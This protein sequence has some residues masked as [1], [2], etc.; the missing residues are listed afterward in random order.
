MAMNLI[1]NTHKFWTYLGLTLIFSIVCFSSISCKQCEL[2]FFAEDDVDTS[3][4]VADLTKVKGKVDWTQP[5]PKK[6]NPANEGQGVGLGSSVRT[7]DNSSTTIAFLDGGRLQLNANSELKLAGKEE[8]FT[9]LMEQGE[10][11]IVAKST[12]GRA[13]GFRLI[14][15]D[16][17]EMVLVREGQ[18]KL[19]MGEA[20][21]QVQMMIGRA[22]IRQG[23]ETINIEA[24]N[25]FM[26]SI[27]KST[28]VER[29]AMVTT[30]KDRRKASRIKDVDGNK[31]KRINKKST[32]IE[33][34]TDIRVA[35][36]RVDLVDDTGSEVWLTNKAHARFEG[37]HKSAKGREG[38]LSLSKGQ[39]KVR[40]RRKKGVSARQEI[41]TPIA[42]VVATTNGLTAETDVSTNKKST[43]VA[44][45]SGKATVTAG[46]KTYHLD[47][48]QSITIKKGGKTDG[49]KSSARPLILAREGVRTRVFFDRKFSRIGFACPPKENSQKTLLELSRKNTFEELI[50]SEP[51]EGKYFIYSA[52]KPGKYFWRLKR[53]MPQEEIGSVGSLEI[54]KDPLAS[55]GS[56]KKL[57][58]VV[59]DTGIQTTVLFQGRAPALTFKWDKHEGA[60]SYRVRVYSED[61]MNTPLVNMTSD[62]ARL[63][64]PAGKLEEGGYFWYQAAEDENGK[65]LKAS[66]MNKLTLSFDNAARLLRIDKPL[67]GQRAKGG[68][69]EVKGL[70]PAG[71]SVTANKRDLSLSADGRFK[72]TLSK[73]NAKVVIFQLK[74]RGLGD[75]F[76]IRHLK[77]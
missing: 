70:A 8:D 2:D 25:S 15:G 19:T 61:E 37:T 77:K 53:L 3:Q 62:K 52:I 18:A 23:N 11:E 38:S 30:L 55:R 39:T 50:I 10:I 6:W 22:L 4:K 49:P 65:E 9:L 60:A 32:V 64:L 24:G 1:F 45:H 21:V 47:A 40:L 69:L 16:T 63:V 75:V 42:M 73:I 54:G 12:E 43:H 29:V 44:V 14:F 41:T 33:P 5:G 72:E 67:T 76:F 31:F 35:K 68:K 58:S 66:Q 13:G 74:K 27:G 28:I 48:S 36:G 51:V 71:S 26:L 20:G 59:P 57:V 46:D 17:S 7:G 56:S 34:G